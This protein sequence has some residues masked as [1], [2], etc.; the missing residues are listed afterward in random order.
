MVPS[1]TV[2]VRCNQVRKRH[3]APALLQRLLLVDRNDRGLQRIHLLDAVFLQGGVVA[4]VVSDFVEDRSLQKIRSRHLGRV[5]RPLPSLP[6]LPVADLRVGREQQH[7]SLSNIAEFER[8]DEARVVGVT[9]QRQ[10]QFGRGAEPVAVD[11]PP[12][13]APVL[14]LCE[15]FLHASLGILLLEGTE[16]LLIA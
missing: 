7:V 8:E 16:S 12:V 5:F 15:E 2:P 13:V 9:L 3:P 10:R 1:C 14:V 4:A 6:G 11:A